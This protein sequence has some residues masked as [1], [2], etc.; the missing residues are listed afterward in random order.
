M[1][2]FIFDD[3][4]FA[5]GGGSFTV[6]TD[7]FFDPLSDCAGTASVPQFFNID[8]GAFTAGFVSFTSRN[9][10]GSDS[11]TVLPDFGVWP[12]TPQPFFFGNNVDSVSMSLNVVNPGDGITTAAA[13]FLLTTF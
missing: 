4:C 11:Q 1:G 10:D 12:G 7:A 2:L 9:A 3:F 13:V 8:G 6:T 5:T